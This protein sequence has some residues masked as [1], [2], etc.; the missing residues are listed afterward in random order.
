MAAATNIPTTLKK[1]Q[2]LSA[3]PQVK[4][5]GGNLKAVVVVAGSGIPNTSK[6]GVQFLTDVLSGNAEVT[7]TGYARQPVTGVTVAF[8]GTL[9]TAVDFSFAN[10]TFSMNAA[11]FTNGRYLIIVDATTG[12]DSTSPVVAVCD[13]NVTF[14]PVAGDVVFSSPTGGLIQWS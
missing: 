11:G 12:I 3:G 9:T 10:I 1:S 13:P 8:D 6:T 2:V 7:G 5:D 14:S 4:F